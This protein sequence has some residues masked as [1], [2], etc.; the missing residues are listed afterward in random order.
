[1]T[2]INYIKIT[3]TISRQIHIFLFIVISSCVLP[4]NNTLLPGHSQ[5]FL[6]TPSSGVD[7]LLIVDES[8][9]MD[10]EH[11]WIVNMTKVLDM[12]LKDIKIGISS[13]NLFGI[14][15]FGSSYEGDSLSRVLFDNGNMFVTSSAITRLTDQ[16]L[17]S[18]RYE[19]GYAAIQFSVSQY[20]FRN[21]AKQFVLISDEERD[22]QQS[23]IDRDAVLRL[24]ENNNI[25]LDVAISQS[26]QSGSGL[27]ALGLDN[28]N[29]TYIYDPLSANLFHVGT[30]GGPVK[31]TAHKTTYFDYTQLA[32]DQG[33][34]AW[35]L[36]LLRQGGNVAKA[37]TNAFVQV[38]AIE[39][40][41]QMTSC[42]NCTCEGN[43]DCVSLNLT[44]DTHECN[45]THGQL[46]NY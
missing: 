6:H 12:A 14:V 23:N 3:R 41:H 15:G 10:M 33:G 5:I 7:I 27:R 45:F 11:Q 35:D 26:F 44:G 21:G 4:N 31:D 29:K 2:R 34:A 13:P 43:L 8:G 24:L 36:S 28:E 20:Q 17:V 38:K 22:V 39:I 30:E 46:R 32:L 19:D 18:G 1:M 9:S 16:L 42:L 25:V 40:F 37:F